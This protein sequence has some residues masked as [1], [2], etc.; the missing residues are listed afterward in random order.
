M[1]GSEIALIIIYD[2]QTGSRELGTVK[3]PVN[4]IPVDVIIR[5]RTANQRADL[6]FGPLETATHLIAT[7]VNG[8]L[9]LAQYL[10]LYETY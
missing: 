2:G 3:I 9:A 1:S 6:G 7:N 4:G 10:T 8:T 5:W